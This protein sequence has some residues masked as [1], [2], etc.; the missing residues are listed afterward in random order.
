MLKMRLLS[1]CTLASAQREI[2]YSEIASRLE[3]SEDEVETWSIKAI[4]AKLVDAKLD[5]CNK[6]LVIRYLAHTQHS[7]Y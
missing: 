5:Q 1:L 4:T 3:I 6:L 7:P 2:Q